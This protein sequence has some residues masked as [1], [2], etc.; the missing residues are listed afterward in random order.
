MHDRYVTATY[1]NL[2]FGFRWHENKNRITEIWGRVKL[3]LCLIN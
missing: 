3:S 2:F 1:K